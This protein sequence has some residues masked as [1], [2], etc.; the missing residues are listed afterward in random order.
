MLTTLCNY[1]ASTDRIEES[2]FKK[3]VVLWQHSEMILRC[4]NYMLSKVD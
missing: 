1:L 2:S 4:F 3:M